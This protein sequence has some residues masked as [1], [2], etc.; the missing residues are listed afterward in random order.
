MRPH[1]IRRSLARP[2]W[3]LVMVSG[4]VLASQLAVDEDSMQLLD[5]RNKSL[6]SNIALRDPAG[7]RDDAE[8]LASGFAEI[9]AFYAQKGQAD[10]AVNWSRQSRQLADDI[11]KHVAANDFDRAAETAV[12]LSKTCRSCHD[13]Y[14]L[15]R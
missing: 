5:D 14:K 15:D 4:S 11:S 7:A 8:A 6:A 10:D 1:P 12:T 9:E 2:T 3:L 13:T